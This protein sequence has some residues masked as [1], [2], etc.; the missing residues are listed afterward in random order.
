MNNKST[1]SGFKINHAVGILV[2]FI[3]WL[4][5]YLLMNSEYIS[6]KRSITK[7]YS[8]KNKFM[9]NDIKII[10]IKFDTNWVK[11]FSE[12]NPRYWKKVRKIYVNNQEVPPGELYKKDDFIYEHCGDYYT[13]LTKKEI[14]SIVYKFPPVNRYEEYVK[15][16]LINSTKD[17]Y[18]KRKLQKRLSRSLPPCD[19][20]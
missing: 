17:F 5:I 1:R 3:F 13:V 15:G 2:F 14:D 18:R 7:S 19:N 20:K 8:W 16:K 11:D 12:V 10:S 6:R 9:I 4:S